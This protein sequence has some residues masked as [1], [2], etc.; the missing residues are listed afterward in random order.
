MCRFWSILYEKAIEFFPW[1]YYYKNWYELRA[2]SINKGQNSKNGN[3]MSTFLWHTMLKLI[4]NPRWRV[5]LA[6]D[7]LILYHHTRHNCIHK[8]IF[9]KPCEDLKVAGAIRIIWLELIER[10]KFKYQVFNSY[11]IY[12]FY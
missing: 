9:L 7:Q 6:L 4:Q 3:F 1:I 5:R 2:Y 10:S 12:R 8:K 11:I